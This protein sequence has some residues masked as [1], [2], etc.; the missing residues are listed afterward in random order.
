MKKCALF[1]WCLLLQ[2]ASTRAEEPSVF[3]EVSRDGKTSYLLGT[4]NSNDPSTLQLSDEVYL[5]LRNSNY[6]HTLMPV[7]DPIELRDSLRYNYSENNLGQ[8]LSSKKFLAL[9]GMCY[10]MLGQSAWEFASAQ[11]LAL[12]YL[13]EHQ[14]AHDAGG[15]SLGSFVTWLAEE[16]GKQVLNTSSG[17]AMKAINSAPWLLQVDYLMAAVSRIYNGEYQDAELKLYLDANLEAL[18]YLQS[19]SEHVEYRDLLVERW[20]AESLAAFNA[21]SDSVFYVADASWFAGRD[22]LLARLAAAGFDVLP[23]SSGLQQVRSTPLDNQWLKAWYGQASLVDSITYYELNGEYAESHLDSIVPRWYPLVSHAGGFT[24]RMPIRPNFSMERKSTQEDYVTVQLYKCE[25]LAINSFY[26]ISHTTY[27]R[28]FANNI[29]LSAFFQDLVKQAVSSISGVLLSDVDI[30]TASV[31]GREIEI[32]LEEGDFVVRS[33]FYLVDN[34]FYQIMV[35][36]SKRTS[37]SDKDNAFMNSLK[38]MNH[39]AAP[40][41]DINLGTVQVELPEKPERTRTELLPGVFSYSFAA[42]DPYTGLKYL[43]SYTPYPAHIMGRSIDQLY[44]AMIFAATDT[45]AGTLLREHPIWIDDLEGREAEIAG[46]QNQYSRLRFIIRDNRLYLLMVSGLGEHIYST[47]AERF[48]YGLH[49]N[50]LDQ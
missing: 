21:N 14:S 1:G 25:D 48:M 5:A 40:W 34:R 32:E 7:F 28:G 38:I 31:K 18:S 9:E 19:I 41:Y 45:L 46:R 29:T 16:Q 30:S 50:E 3:F 6:V 20:K 24:G 2:V 35:G 39:N 27:P 42:Q 11:P 47:L 37:Y 4:I 36:N 49:A 33:R 26:T 13:L 10:R 12:R 17:D 22:G 15:S 44:N 8:Q 23:V 43:H